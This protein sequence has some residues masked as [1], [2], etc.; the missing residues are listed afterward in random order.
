MTT[1]QWIVLV[2]VLIPGLILMAVSAVWKLRI[3]QNGKKWE[4]WR[5]ERWAAWSS[6]E[7]Q[8]AADKVA[9]AV[10]KPEEEP[11]EDPPPPPAAGA[12]MPREDGAGVGREDRIPPPHP[13]YGVVV[14]IHGDARDGTNPGKSGVPRGYEKTVMR[15]LCFCGRE[16]KMLRGA[17]PP[18]CGA[19]GKIDIFVEYAMSDEEAL[20]QGMSC[21]SR[22]WLIGHNPYKE[23][24]SVRRHK[25]WEMGWLRQN[26]L[27]HHGVD[28]WAEA[29]RAQFISNTIKRS[30]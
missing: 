14:P 26:I 2:L 23:L 13:P 4:T 8:A 30:L 15:C 5:K 19:C 24:V 3:R 20:K 21:R 29:Q 9:E 22:N 25:F 27:V 17:Q 6:E 28:L 12:A 10:N 11:P 7:Q 18:K 16:F 1:W